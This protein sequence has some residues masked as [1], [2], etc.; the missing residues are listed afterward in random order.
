MINAA[1]LALST[2]KL[3]HTPLLGAQLIEFPGTFLKRQWMIRKFTIIPII[4]QK[5]TL[6]NVIRRD[7]KREASTSI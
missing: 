6:Q 3:P 4:S 7:P 1:G 2:P 5:V